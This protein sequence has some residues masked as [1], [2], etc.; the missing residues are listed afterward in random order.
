MPIEIATENDRRT[1]ERRADWHTPADCYELLSVQEAMDGFGKQLASGHE[2]MNSLQALIA[3]N[4]ETSAADRELIKQTLLENNMLA[5][6]D[7]D[8][9][10]RQLAKNSDDFHPAIEFIKSAEGFVNGAR[11]VGK[12]GRRVVMWFFP[13]ATAII[14]FVYAINQAWPG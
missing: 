12:W 3:S 14:S 11:A 7:R 4:A 2:R 10:K 9:I 6:A 13:A 8:E 5:A 1:S